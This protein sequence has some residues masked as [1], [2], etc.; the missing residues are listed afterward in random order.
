MTNRQSNHFEELFT[1]LEFRI[2][3]IA[4]CTISMHHHQSQ[5]DHFKELFTLLD[6][7][8]LKKAKSTISMHLKRSISFLT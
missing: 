5:S 8:I 6:F 1:L 4:K 3:K 2:L 7:R